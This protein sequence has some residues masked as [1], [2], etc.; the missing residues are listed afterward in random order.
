MR[1][2][3]KW[4]IYGIFLI[5][6]I[7]SIYVRPKADALTH[8]SERMQKPEET[9]VSQASEKV[10]ETVTEKWTI[11]SGKRLKLLLEYMGD[12]VNFEK[13]G[14]SLKIPGAVAE[15]WNVKE[16]GTIQ[17]FVQKTSDRS[18]EI[19]LYKGTREITDIPGSQVVL[20]VREVFPDVAAETIEVT[21][22]DG[23]KADILFDETRKLLTIRTDQTGVFHVTGQ[24]NEIKEKPYVAAA[25]VAVTAL[26]VGIRTRSEK[27]GDR[28][29]K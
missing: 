15:S 8:P 5:V 10:T 22:P 1:K 11:I 6:G 9:T 14:I 26:T 13:D 28:D 19:K 17:S 18:Y 24:R 7:A 2:L 29:K 4:I 3:Q 23:K 16:N 12:D 20:P 21:D 27:W 25:M